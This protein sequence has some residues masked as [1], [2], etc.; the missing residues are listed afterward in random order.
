[1]NFALLVSNL[2][3]VYEQLTLHAQIQLSK[4]SLAVSIHSAIK[5]LMGRA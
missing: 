3:S 4:P 1:M 2:P 5:R